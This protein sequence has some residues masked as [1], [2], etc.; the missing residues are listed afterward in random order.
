MIVHAAASAKEALLLYEQNKD[1]DLVVSD[2]R[3]PE[4][5]GTELAESILKFSSDQKI[6]LYSGFADYGCVSKL[7]MTNNVVFVQK[8]KLASELEDAILDII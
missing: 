5:S 1:Y 7:A 4:V 8:G 3:M 2:V 6:L